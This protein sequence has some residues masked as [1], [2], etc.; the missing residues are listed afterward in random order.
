VWFDVRQPWRKLVRAC[1]ARLSMSGVIC[2]LG[3]FRGLLAGAKFTQVPANPV[4][5]PVG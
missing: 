1:D 4:C 5:A 3:F 2:S